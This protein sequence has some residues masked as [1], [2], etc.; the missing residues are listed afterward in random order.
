MTKKFHKQTTTMARIYKT[1][2]AAAAGK[3]TAG[4]LGDI[5]APVSQPW[6]PHVCKRKHKWGEV[7]LYN[8]RCTRCGTEE[9]KDAL[10]RWNT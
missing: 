9:S 4:S 8:R 2:K 6:Q 5:Q 1:R 7:T 10:G 3:L